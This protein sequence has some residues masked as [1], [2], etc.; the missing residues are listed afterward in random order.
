MKAE[1][2]RQAQSLCARLRERKDGLCTEAAEEIE[3]TLT[4]FSCLVDQIAQLREDLRDTR[5]N[6]DSTHRLLARIPLAARL[7][8]VHGERVE[9]RG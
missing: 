7:E 1:S 2:I 5:K 3:G 6:L 4:A 8:A 9:E